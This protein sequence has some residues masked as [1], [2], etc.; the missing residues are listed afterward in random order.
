MSVITFYSYKGGVGRSMALANVAVLLAQRQ[1]RVLVIDW[2]LEAPGVDRY[3]SDLQFEPIGNGLLPLL[4]EVSAGKE[5]DYL[6]FTWKLSALDGTFGFTFLHSGRE[7]DAEYYEHLE[8]F[9]WLSFFR[10][11]GGKYLEGLRERWLSEFDFVLIDS[12]TGLTDAGGVCTIQLPDIVVAVFT[13]ARQSLFGVRDVMRLAQAARQRLAYD[14]PT[15]SVVPVPSRVDRQQASYGDWLG[16]FAAEM[17]EFFSEWLPQ[18]TDRFKVLDRLALDHSPAMIHGERLA[19]HPAGGDKSLAASYDR[20][21]TVL[22]SDLSDISPIV[23]APP[24]ERRPFVKR[25]RENDDYK[26]DVYVSYPR[27]DMIT[28]WLHDHLLPL[29]GDWMTLALGRELQFFMDNAEIAPSANWPPSQRLV[30]SR[31]RV[32]LAL[33]SPLYFASRWCLAEFETFRLRSELVGQSLLVPMILHGGKNLPLEAQTIQS[34]D[35]SRFV[36][37]GGAFRQSQ[38]YEEFD[39]TIKK[40]SQTLTAALENT[41]PWN[42]DWPVVEPNDVR[43]PKPEEV[44]IP[45]FD[46]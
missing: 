19:V 30:L 6:Q 23:E 40:W 16:Q 5:P 3:F 44:E 46:A 18:Q 14:R 4:R 39:L 12:R 17:D 36:V 33:W 13:A 41:P 15:L 42:S 20:L 26:Y 1:Y 11:G 2:D 22:A 37:T 27:T 32:M 45:R 34:L 31:S 9:E 28:R 24:I 38:R 35:V 29:I 10:N 21:S 8:H 25:V 7:T 43:V